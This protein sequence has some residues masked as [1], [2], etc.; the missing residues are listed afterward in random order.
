MYVPLPVRGS[1]IYDDYLTNICIRAT[2]ISVYR[3]LHGLSVKQA[4]FVEEIF[5]IP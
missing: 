3:F 5:V 4:Y 2:F 1:Y